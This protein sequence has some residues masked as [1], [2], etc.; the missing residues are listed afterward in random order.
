MK[1]RQFIA[2]SGAT[3][4]GLSGVPLVVRAQKNAPGIT[5]KEIKLGQSLPLSG[6]AASYGTIGKALAAWFESVNADGG[7]N[8]RRLS[9]VQLDDGYSPP[10]TVEQSRRLV[11][12]EQVA[13]VV[14]PMGTP[15]S[16]AAR[17]YFNSSKVPQ[18]FIGSGAAAWNDDVAKY[19]WSLGWQPLF[20]DEGRTMARHIL[21]TRPGAKI[22]V[23][24]QNDDAGKDLVRGLKEGLG[25]S[26]KQIV[27]EESHEVTDP[28][29]DSQV[30]TMQSS[31]ADVLVMWGSPKATIQALRK[32]HDIGWRPAIYINQ[33]SSSVPTVLTPV[34]LDKVKGVISAA[35]LKD[36]ADPTWA[37]DPGLKAWVAFMDKYNAGAV[38]DY[39]A[40]YGT[41]VAQTAVQALKQCGNDLS[42]ENIMRQTRRLDL[43]LPMLLPGLRIKTSDAQPHPVRDLRLQQFDGTSWRLMS[44]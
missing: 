5:D 43:E 24:Y 26:V 9:L 27:R 22:A 20:T 39:N 19:P 2:L 11:E 28:T 33:N 31:G 7:I 3:L 21:Q 29:V 32:T 42:R 14:N 17:S 12:R 8:G 10:K 35:F 34:G 30:V 25:G 18:L 4:A 13:F 41:C 16:M 38:K 1:K 44:A 40:V 23:L 36:P 6:P 37:N 15:T